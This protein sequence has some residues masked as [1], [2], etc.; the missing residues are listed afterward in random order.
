MREEILAP[1]IIQER[2]WL[3][4]AR[5][6]RHVAGRHLRYIPR[7]RKFFRHDI[8]QRKSSA[9]KDDSIPV[10]FHRPDARRAAP[11]IRPVGRF[12]YSA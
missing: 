5:K 11:L 4:P 2:P 3:M 6:E 9:N 8:L 10:N 7:S 1:D 12:P